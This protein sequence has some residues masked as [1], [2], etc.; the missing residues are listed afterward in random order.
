MTFINFLYSGD[1]IPT[2]NSLFMRI[3]ISL[4][5][6]TGI[7]LAISCEKDDICADANANT[8]HLIIT[9]HDTASGAKKAVNN[10]MIQGLD[11]TIYYG[12]ASTR[13]SIAIP[14]RVLTN[15]TIFKLFKDYSD[16]NTAN[17]MADDTGNIDTITLNYETEELFISRACG[18]KTIFNN[19]TAGFTT[20][21]DN[22]ITTITVVNNKI[23]N[24]TNAHVRISH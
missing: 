15:N 2:L 7:L 14:L 4:L 8:P 9:F 20:D 12:S 22:W 17:N 6:I 10:L 19:L 13:D 3:F 23:E 5:V 1:K 18:Y 16:N 21:S 11:Q 24:E